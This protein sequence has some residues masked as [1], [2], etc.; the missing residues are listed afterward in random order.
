VEEFMAAAV[1]MAGGD[2]GGSN[3]MTGD[4]ARDWMAAQGG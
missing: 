2:A 3:V 1:R 4:A